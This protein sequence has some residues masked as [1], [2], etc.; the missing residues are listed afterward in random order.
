MSA[1]HTARSVTVR[2]VSKLSRRRRVIGRR[3]RDSVTSKPPVTLHATATATAMLACTRDGSQ[4][5][6]IT[7]F[8]GRAAVTALHRHPELNAHINDDSMTTFG[9][10]NLGIAVDA[11]AGLIVPVVRDAH[12]LNA[13]ELTAS[14]TSAAVKVRDGA[15]TPDD[16]ADATFTVTSLG[17]FGVEQ[18]TPILDPPQVAVLG[19]GCIGDR[20]IERDGEI[21][22]EPIVHLSL[23]FDHAAV[24][25]APAA[26]FLANLVDEIQHSID[27]IVT[28]IS[29]PS[30]ET[31]TS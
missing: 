27:S 10:V 19:I 24:D 11:S 1:D 18:F 8:I 30:K 7:G 13:A 22:L 31:S 23:T 6:T 9:V 12:M 14:I 29:P 26:R 16:L 4:R 25:G 20:A 15:I 17:A 28:Q 21:G 2:D 3:L 5:V